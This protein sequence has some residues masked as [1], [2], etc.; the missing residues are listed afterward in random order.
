MTIF[1]GLL[2]VMKKL[3]VGKVIISKQGED[4]E[5][6]KRFKRIVDNKKI[7][8]VVVKKRRQIEY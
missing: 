4:S 5:N 3:K 8:V 6:L 1:G 2:S 7:K